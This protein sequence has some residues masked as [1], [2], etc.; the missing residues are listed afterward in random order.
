[1]TGLYKARVSPWDGLSLHRGKVTRRAL[2]AEVIALY[3]Y[4]VYR[5]T[6]KNGQRSIGRYLRSG[7]ARSAAVF[8]ATRGV[9][10]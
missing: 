2:Y 8:A 6:L 1:V 5:Q 9:Q 4:L 3:N 10:T 7:D